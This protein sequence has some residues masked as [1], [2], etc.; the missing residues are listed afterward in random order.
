MSLLNELRD[1]AAKVHAAG[2]S[3]G[4]CTGTETKTICTCLIVDGANPGP[5]CI[6]GWHEVTCLSDPM[7]HPNS[8]PLS[9]ASLAR[10]VG[11]TIGLFTNAVVEFTIAAFVLLCVVK[12]IN[13]N[14]KNLSAALPA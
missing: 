13:A 4:P 6:L 14:T 7:N 1:G 10:R 12:D 5:S 8:V 11:R 9:P 2:F 3:A